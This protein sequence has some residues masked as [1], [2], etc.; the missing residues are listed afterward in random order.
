MK[1]LS[2]LIP[3]NLQEEKQNFFADNTYNPRFIY[4]EAVPQHKLEKYPVPDPKL[5]LLA[6]KI[7]AA[8]HEEV[9]DERGNADP[10]RYL[11]NEEVTLK[12]IQF[13]KIH[14]LDQKIKIKW[15]SSFIT[16][17]TMN[18]EFLKLKSDAVF[19]EKDTIS[20]LFHEV[21]THALRRLNYEQQP[22]FLK[23]KKFGFSDYLETEEGLA[24]LHGL[25]A[26]TNKSLFST[27][28]RFLAVE[29]GLTMTFA[30]L[31]Q[32][33]E[34]YFPNHERRW[35]AVLRQKR[36]VQDTRNPSVF[37]KDALYF[38][39][40]VRMARWLDRHNYDLTGLYFGKIS[41]KDVGKARELNAGYLP[42][43]PIFYLADKE[44]YISG[45][46]EII[47]KNFCR[48]FF[49]KKFKASSNISRILC[50]R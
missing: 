38:S 35:T 11:S 18:E 48:L 24:V 25:L 44:K 2:Q 10:D 26:T 49:E 46:K 17:A 41:S 27:A 4:T 20:M 45:I 29:K 7:V 22:W 12:S 43:L 8:H 36:G 34:P 39:G 42:K 3:A 32:Y 50:E 1:F 47:K 13:L 21:G 31:W 14:G 19:T 23:K 40:S 28:V 16:R 30:E 37:M 15:S 5:V 9:I 6:E 33:L